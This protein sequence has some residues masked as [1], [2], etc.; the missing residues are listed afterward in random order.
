MPELSNGYF[1]QKMPEV[2]F[3]GEII[4]ATGF[5][6]H[7]GLSVYY[8]FIWDS[9]WTLL[10]GNACGQTHTAVVSWSQKTTSVPLNHPLDIHF[11]AP[12]TVGWPKILVIIRGMD[13]YGRSLISGYG[14]AHLPTQS[15][16]HCIDIHCWRP[17]GS[18]RD[19]IAAFFLGNTAHLTNDDIIC[20]KAAWTS[21]CRLVTVPAGNIKLSFSVIL[22]HF[23]RYGMDGPFPPLRPANTLGK[24]NYEDGELP[25]SY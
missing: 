6:L 21:R 25:P 16:F 23:G 9:P 2:N 24:G 14:F 19:E 20:N 10:Q 4:E 22:R 17:T 8:K 5:H 11:A 7:Q 3:I 15:G 1:N 13:S 18:M 12:S